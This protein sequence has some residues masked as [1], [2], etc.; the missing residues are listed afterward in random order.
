MTAAAGWREGLLTSIEGRS[1]LVI[2]VEFKGS[3]TE[4][5]SRPA[6][7]CCGSVGSGDM[8]SEREGRQGGD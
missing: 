7:K 3:G 8:Q 2:A 4:T 5:V 1:L 6:L